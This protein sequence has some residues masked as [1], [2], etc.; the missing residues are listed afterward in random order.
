[1]EYWEIEELNKLKDEF[2]KALQAQVPDFEKAQKLLERGLDI[3]A[4]D[5]YGESIIN[6]CL[7][8]HSSFP[9]E[10]DTCEEGECRT[11]EGK[12]KSKII[13]IIEFFIKNGWDSQRYGLDCVAS[14]V[15]TTHDVQMFEAA[16]RILECPMSNNEHDYEEALESIGTEESFQRC[17]EECHEQENLYYAMYELVE[18]KMEGRPFKG[19]YPYYG[20]LGK[21]IDKIVYFSDKFDFNETNRGTEFN[22]DFGFLCGEELFVVRSCVNIL[23]M[24]NRI[25]EKPQIDASSVFGD[26]VIGASV[27]D[28]SFEHVKKNRE[29]SC[30]G[31]PIIILKLDS[32]KE[33]RFT[34]NFG[35]LPDNEIQ[36]RFLTA[37][38]TKI[39]SDKRSYLFDLC[40]KSIIDLDKIE[41]YIVGAKLSGA[42]ITRTA[43]SLAEEF[44]WEIGAFKSRCERDPEPSELVTSNW[45]SLF[46]LFIPY[47]LDSNLVFRENGRNYYNLLRSLKHLDNID[48][49]YK[50]Y[51]ILFKNGA[52]PNIIIDDESFFEEIDCN[53][54]MDATL[55]EIDGEDKEIYEKFFRLW[56]LMMAYGGH[57]SNCGKII[58]IKE[59]FTVDAFENCESFSYKKEVTEND[60]FLHIHITKT[61]EE[62]AVL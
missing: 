47:G 58:D 2:F 30:Y 19:I 54:V 39:I 41:A 62:V 52:D 50:L 28:V 35:E 16:K 40:A 56:L 9:L 48:I 29:K 20:V 55:M 7:L 34:H 38:T 5:N 51:R 22:N 45:L 59:G 13:P 36:A 37:E 33:I 31:Q 14:L 26:G 24:N 11:C 60:W 1:M 23:M 57:R 8:M 12:K 3:N 18:A 21:K 61:G 10:C 17:C 53:V 25:Y 32:G 15:H 46:N 4:A 43:I 27:V 44:A 49:I 6:N 42:D